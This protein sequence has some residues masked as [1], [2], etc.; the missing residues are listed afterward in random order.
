MIL[1]PKLPP[2]FI[3]E[4]IEISG[5]IQMMVRKHW[6]QIWKFGWYRHNTLVGPVWIRFK[7]P[8]SERSPFYQAKE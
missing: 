5:T 6:W 4:I 3:P 1:G 2:L 8:E 7:W